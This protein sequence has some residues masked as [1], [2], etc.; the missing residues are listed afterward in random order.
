MTSK[1]WL[2]KGEYFNYKQHQIFKREAG[3]GETLILIHGFPTASYDWHKIWKQL[4]AHFHVIT[5]D[6]IGFGFSD[7]V[8][9]LLQSSPP[10]SN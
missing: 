1:E 8:Q 6:M 9:L 3:V 4:V 7:K 2:N 5:I 10:S